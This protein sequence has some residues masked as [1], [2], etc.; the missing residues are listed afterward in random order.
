MHNFVISPMSL[1]DWQADS[2][3]SAVTLALADWSAQLHSLGKLQLAGASWMRN[4]WP[5]SQR[6]R[7]LRHAQRPGKH[8]APASEFEMSAIGT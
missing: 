5:I 4:L 8:R 6:P 3:L 7:T 1:H 2:K